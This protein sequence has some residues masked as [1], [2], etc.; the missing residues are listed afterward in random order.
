MQEMKIILDGLHKGRFIAVCAM[1]A[2]GAQRY[3]CTCS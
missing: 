2:C 3:S 1:K